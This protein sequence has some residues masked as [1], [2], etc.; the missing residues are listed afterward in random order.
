MAIRKSIAGC[1]IAAATQLQ[2]DQSKEI[3]LHEVK[4]ARIKLADW[5]KPK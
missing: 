2:Q 4:K 3:L 1:L 5:I